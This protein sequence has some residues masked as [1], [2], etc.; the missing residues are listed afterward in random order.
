MFL[1]FYKHSLLV[2]NDIVE[3]CSEWEAEFKVTFHIT[4]ELRLE[5]KARVLGWVA[6]EVDSLAR[7]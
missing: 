4:S 6:P 7:I 5:G 3:N 2:V 1:K